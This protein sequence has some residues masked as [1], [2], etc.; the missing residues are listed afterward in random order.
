MTY[1]KL[2]FHFP[3]LVVH[4]V[5]YIIVS[6]P[7]RETTSTELQV[8][9]IVKAFIIHFGITID[10]M[11]SVFVECNLVSMFEIVLEFCAESLIHI[12]LYETNGL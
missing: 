11:N 10:K 6:D 2:R 8:R 1:C 3:C 7:F 4:L 12:S 5:H 9:S